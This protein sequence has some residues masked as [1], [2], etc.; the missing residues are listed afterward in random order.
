[1]NYVRNSAHKSQVLNYKKVFVRVHSTSFEM[2]EIEKS[3]VYFLA[4][5]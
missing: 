5:I 4:N 1:M 3:L 2:W